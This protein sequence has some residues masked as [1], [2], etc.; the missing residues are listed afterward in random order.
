MPASLVVHVTNM[1]LLGPWDS[2]HQN[3]FRHS[4]EHVF[5][6]RHVSGELRL[7][8]SHAGSEC[9]SVTAQCDALTSWG[10]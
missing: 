1:T 10:M 4:G 9:H 5:R 2:Q 3:A 6:Q 7:D 8:F